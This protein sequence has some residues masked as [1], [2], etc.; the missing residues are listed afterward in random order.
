MSG[1][2]GLEV[3]AD[4]TSGPPRLALDVGGTSTRAALVRGARVLERREAATPARAGPEA[5]VAA[6]AELLAPL[7]GAADVVCVAATGRVAGGR[8]TAVNPATLPG[9]DAFPFAEALAARCGLPVRVV[10]D[11]HAAAW[12]EARWGAGRGARDFVFVTVSTGVGGGIVAGGRLLTGARGL[13]GHLGFLGSGFRP[14]AGA[15]GEGAPP[16]QVDAVTGAAA[17]RRFL[18]QHASGSAIARLGSAAY[19]AALTTREVFARAAAGDPRAE[20]VLASAVEALARALVDLRWLVDPARVALGGS[21]GLAPGY[22]GRLRAALARLE[23]D[24]PLAV[25]AAQL[26]ADAGLIGAADLLGTGDTGG[27]GAT[28]APDAFDGELPAG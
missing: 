9:W 10:N 4:R 14:A 21:V 8:V 24:D 1:A 17:P 18:E 16:G 6:A 28:E 7:A 23:P 15:G 11:A 5:V 19:G 13:A 12:G 25:V 26:G 2:V 22:L 27:G 3:R 20:A